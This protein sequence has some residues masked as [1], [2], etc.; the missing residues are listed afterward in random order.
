MVG[1]AE[2]ARLDAGD[3]AA[4]VA[5]REVKP[6]ELVEAAIERIEALNPTLNAVVA[7]A[8]DQAVDAT[9]AMPVDDTRPFAGVPFLLKDLI[10]EAA[11]MPFTEGSRF[12]RDHVSTHDQEL[13]VRLRRAGFVI[14]GKTNTPEFGTAP[15][16]E[17]R[18]FGPTRNPWD[19]ER[20]TAGSSGG[21]AAAVASGMVPAAHAN[22]LGGSIR[23]PASCCGLFGLK[24]TR[25]RVPL[26]PEYADP[27]GAMAVEHAVTRTVRDSAAILDAIAGPELGEPFPAPPLA[28]PLRDEV[29]Q[30]VGTLRIAFSAEA[31]D[32]HPTDP[33]CVTALDEAV[34]LCDSL[35]HHLEER[36]LPPLRPEVGEAI[37][38]FWGGVVSWIV[39]YWIRKV[40]RQPGP[41][42]LEPLTRAFWEGG[43]QT[44]AGDYLLAL[45]EL[46]RY[47]RE[48]AAFFQEVDVWLTPTLAQPPPRL[49]EMQSDDADPMAG[50]RRSSQFVAFPGIVANI[51]GNPAMSVPLHWSAAGLPIGVHALGRFGDEATLIRLAAQLEQAQPWAAR[52]PPVHAATPPSA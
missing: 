27:C 2:L 29:D 35:G 3:Q 11:G 34:R 13:V 37:G 23:Y 4:L 5:R 48:V 25:G 21:S 38:T 49:G 9:R 30:P 36:W 43:R 8:Y 46:R 52:L 19:L 12:L 33:V 10:T 22:D 41:D 16:C 17:P 39:E 28:R 31:A 6:A 15:H 24:P 42:E 7:T 40:G 44:S 51:T 26:G 20:S 32:G 45:E 18:L 50:L 1:A 14:L 47:S